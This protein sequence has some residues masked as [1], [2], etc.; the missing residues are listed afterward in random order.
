MSPSA[1]KP[2]H[3]WESDVNR[4]VGSLNALCG[5]RMR[6][7][8]AWDVKIEMLT[9]LVVPARWR[10]SVALLG[11]DNEIEQGPVSVEKNSTGGCPFTAYDVSDHFFKK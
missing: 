6:P 11:S 5:G 1:D 7:G 9:E 10:I 4:I 8:Q 3:N 2:K